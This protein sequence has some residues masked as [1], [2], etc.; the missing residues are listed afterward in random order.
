MHALPVELLTHIFTLFCSGVPDNASLPYPAW[1]PITHVC[2]HWRTIVLSRGQLWT[3]I[4]P[5]LSLRW[6][7]AFM[8]R[9][10]TMLTDF[11]LLVYPLI[12]PDD[13]TCLLPEDIIPLLKDFMRLRSLSLTGRS[14]SIS[15]IM[16]SLRCS[17]PIQ[18]LSLCLRDTERPFILPKDLFLGKAPIRHLQLITDYGRIVAPGWLLHGVT[19]FTNNA[20]LT[21]SELLDDLHQMSQSALTHLEYRRPCLQHWTDSDMDDLPMSPIQMPQLMNLIVGADSADEFILLNRLL[22]P[23]VDAKRRLEMYVSE[24]Y[25]YCSVLGSFDAHRINYLSQIVE[26]AYGF[27]NIH[28][29][30]A[31][32]ECWCRLWTGGAV[33]T[34]EDAKF[35]LSFEW[36]GFRKES[37][38]DFITVCDALGMARVRKLV[39]DSTYP[40]PP[41]STWWKF[42]ERLPGIEEL[43]LYSASV[44]TLGAAW[45]V[46]LAPAVL[47]ALR[48][49]RIVDPGEVTSPLQYTIIG[50]PPVRKIV[51][52]SRSTEGVVAPFPEMVPA[53][54]ELENMSKGLLRLLRV[55][56]LGSTFGSKKRKRE[57]GRR[58]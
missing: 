53:E 4:T 18:S 44:D 21:P 27:K 13:R 40:G 54:K 25:G 38:H 22:R 29:S 46:N 32:T 57:K 39:I 56:D 47:P 49:V 55:G 11:N 7:R 37:L 14:S 34:W 17:L 2:H 8:E 43:E 31:P 36:A 3:S 24:A 15:P 28:I 33:T 41:M 58:R 5:G 52:L 16:N 51:R 23:H 6:I 50:D 1:L 42:L 20:P 35:C 26:A 48:R 45:K 19:H 30:G 9:S 10:K 12:W